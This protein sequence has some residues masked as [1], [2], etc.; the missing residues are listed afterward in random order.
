MDF[1]GLIF[2]YRRPGEV[3]THTRNVQ[4]NLGRQMYC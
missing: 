3:L 2:L 1:Q 4:T